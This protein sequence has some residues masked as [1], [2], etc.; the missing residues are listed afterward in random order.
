[1]TEQQLSLSRFYKGWDVYQ[2]HLVTAIAP[3]TAELLT[4]R[5]SQ[6]HWSVGMIATHIVATRAW[7]FHTR[8]GEGSTDIDPL[9]LWDRWDEM[10]VPVRSATELVD[11]LERTW[12][13]VQDALTRWTAADLEYVFPAYDEE[14]PA[15]SRQYI[16][17]HVLEHDIHHG[18]EISSILGA[19]GLAA[20]NI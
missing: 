10:E 15:R 13:M 6:H 18:G 3:L 8:M 4:L 19:H 5:S 7:W 2:R 1:M 16:I 20:V 9:G 12:Q 14:S 17:W 11:G